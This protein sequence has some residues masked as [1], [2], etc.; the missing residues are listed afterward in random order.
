MHVDAGVGEWLGRQDER[1]VLVVERA[2]GNAW[3]VPVVA[4]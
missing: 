4:H 1:G 3:V 2:L